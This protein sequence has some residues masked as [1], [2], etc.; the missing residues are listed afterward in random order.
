MIYT[1]GRPQLYDRAIEEFAKLGNQLL[2]LGR[3]PGYEGGEVFRTAADAQSAIDRMWSPRLRHL[4]AGYQVD[5]DW[6]A[7]TYPVGDGIHCLMVDRPILGRHD[8]APGGGIAGKIPP[9]S[10]KA[11]DLSE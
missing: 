6:Y 8:L 2:L 10:P 11:F 1:I 4:R 7:D 3:H 9:P 5:A